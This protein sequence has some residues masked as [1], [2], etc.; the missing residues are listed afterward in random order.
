MGRRVLEGVVVAALAGAVFVVH[1]VTYIFR[2]PFWLDEAW[3]AISTR[4]PIERLTLLTSATPIGFSVL[5][6]A[7]PGTGDQRFRLVPLL[8]AAATVVVAYLLGRELRL[9][10]VLTGALLGFAALMVPAMLIRDDL[11]SYTCDAFFTVLL[12]VLLARLETAWTKGRLAALA[13]VGA[14]AL[15]F[16]HVVALVTGCIFLALAAVL[17]VRR[18]TPS[19]VQLAIAGAAMLLVQS[20]VYLVFDRP[21]KTLATTGYWYLF[22]L[23]VDRG[24]SGGLDFIGQKLRIVAPSVGAGSLLL[25]AILAA[26]G[27]ATLVRLDRPALALTIPLLVVAELFASALHLYPF[28]DQRTSTF[29][30]VALA[31][32]MAIGVAGIF[33]WVARRHVIA[34]AALLLLVIG[35]WVNAAA[36]FVRSHE[37]PVADLGSVARYIDTERRP[38]D[39]VVLS[40]SSS[41]EFLYYTKSAHPRYVSTTATPIGYRPVSRSVPWLVIP[42][43]RTPKQIGVALREGQDHAGPG[44]RVW[45]VT[46]HLLGAERDTWNAEIERLHMKSIA[47]YFSRTLR[48]DAATGRA[49]DARRRS[50]TRR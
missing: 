47:A 48:Y 50:R 31:L 7:V 46:S 35:L 30:L 32:L 34:A 26:A 18:R 2:Y 21:H 14:L 10:R 13:V 39:M 24:L 4:S 44:G 5:L 6:R 12:L 3:V 23:P 15:L 16:S 29:L 8:F 36:P 22:Y 49:I 1:D 40:F 33:A 41:Y 20:A 9:T 28:L 38:G 17:L 37:I 42:R 45:V 25:V 19:L 27:I 43:D 11:K